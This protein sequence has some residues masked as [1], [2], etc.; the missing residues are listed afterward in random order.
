MQT[1]CLTEWNTSDARSLNDQVD[2]Y[3]AA[4]G[5]P[6][7]RRRGSLSRRKVDHSKGAAEGITPIVGHL[8]DGG[9][10]LGTWDA[11]PVDV[12]TGPDGAL[13]FSD[14]FGTRIF[15]LGYKP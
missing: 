7:T 13:Y 14:D 15:R 11:R 1:A 5:A 2:H 12:R 4:P 8:A 10:E 9:L 3:P 6:I